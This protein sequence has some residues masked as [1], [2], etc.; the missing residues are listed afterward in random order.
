MPN[1]T[2][3]RETSWRGPRGGICNACGNPENGHAAVGNFCP[4]DVHESRIGGFPVGTRVIH[5]TRGPGTVVAGTAD[6][7]AY[8]VVLDEWPGCGGGIIVNGRRAWI[9]ERSALRLLDPLIIGARVRIDGA[10]RTG[11]IIEIREHTY[12]VHLDDGFSAVHSPS[13]VRCGA[14]SRD[15]LTLLDEPAMIPGMPKPIKRYGPYKPVVR[16]LGG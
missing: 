15:S 2:S 3:R 1:A 6:D 11:T 5:I 16:K 10:N 14:Y 9:S 8:D 7:P 13:G 4:I 12:Y